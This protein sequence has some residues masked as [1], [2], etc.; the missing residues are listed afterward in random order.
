M[1]V[2]LDVGARPD[3]RSFRS[4]ADKAERYFGD[5]SERIGKRFSDNMSKG[6]KSSDDVVRKSADT[7]V[8]AYERAADAAGRV[9]AEEAKL[10]DLREKGAGR[11]AL[12]AQSERLEKARRSEVSSTR[13]AVGALGEL[14]NAQRRA[15]SSGSALSNLLGGI[16]QGAAGTRLGDLAGQAENLSTRLG[17]ISPMAAGATAGVAALVIGVGAASKALYDLGA[18]WDDIGDGIA[19]RTGKMGSDLKSVTDVVRSVGS[20]VAAP[21][22]QIGDVAGRVSQS[23]RLSGQPLEDMVRTVSQLNEL[24]GEQT[25]VRGLGKAFRQFGVDSTADQMDALEGLASASRATGVSVNDLIGVMNS[26]GKPAKELGLDFGQTAGLVTTLEEAGLDFTKAAPSLSIALKNF[27][28]DGREPQQA[29]RDTVA[30][31]KNLIDAGKDAQAADLAAKTFGKGYIDFLAAIKSGKLDVDSFN[32]ALKKAGPTIDE[33][34][35]STEDWHEE[36]QKLKNT[37]S[38]DLAPAAGVFFGAVNDWLKRTT[39]PLSDLAN[40]LGRINDEMTS[41]AHNAAYGNSRPIFPGV[42]GAQPGTPVTDNLPGLFTPGAGSGT[43]S[44]GDLLTGAQGVPVAGAPGAAPTMALP[45]GL[46]WHPDGGFQARSSSSSGG[47][48]PTFPEDQWKVP[49]PQ[50][51]APVTSSKAG[52]GP[53]GEPGVWQADANTIAD[54]QQSVISTAQSLSEANLHL[55]ELKSQENVAQSA[56]VSAQNNVQQAAAAAD[57]AQRELLESQQGTWKK[58]E[59][60]ADSMSKGMDSIGSALDND[61]GIS[62]GLPGL[63]ENLVKFL[64]NLAFAPALGALSAVSAASPNQGSGLVGVMAANGAFGQQYTPSGVVPVTVTNLPGGGSGSLSAL[65]PGASIPGTYGLP[66]GTDTGGY[67]SSGKAFPAWV[68]AL[69]DRFGVKASTYSGHQ[70]GDR[71]E[72]G[73][74][75]NPG[76]QNRGIDWSG[77]VG[78]MQQFADYLSQI[79]GSLEQAIWQNPSTGRSTEIAGGRSQPGYFAGDLGGHQNHVHTRQSA[80]IPAPGGFS[81]IA[82]GLGITPTPL[83]VSA[84]GGGTGTGA[85]FPGIGGPPQAFGANSPLGLPMTGTA[86]AAAP[87]AGAVSG[88][89]AYPAQGGGGFSGLGGMPMD[90]MMMATSGLDAMAPGAGV[91]AKIGIQLANRT[92]GYMGQVAGIGAS[93]LLETLSVGDNPMGS[94]GKSWIGKLAGGFAGARP[95]LPNMAGQKP[96]PAPGGQQGQPGQQGGTT[97]QNVTINNQAAT[98]DQNG[99]D[100]T[101]HLGAMAAPAGRQ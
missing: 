101:A 47:A 54:R 92:I 6:I 59:G 77:P 34:N 89:Q 78:A 3:E 45:P 7:A 79:P 64:A 14:D 90:A 8:K 67:G 32:D 69:E 2:Y 10:E 11:T 31:I 60:V 62:K 71:H 55:L 16:S 33:L 91:A 30:E 74:A 46:Q 73:Y 49:I 99:K 83:G 35:K 23:L 13:A 56:L 36:W 61:L 20:D 52:I 40:E 68:H 17:G 42:P 48:K 87:N 81:A 66:T 72:A 65:Q 75:P 27:A 86:G 15:A 24:T 94:F 43:P 82:P 44:L 98:P 53:N 84:V 93:G 97:N 100:I 88:G 29:L 4:A 80:P 12:I 76:H 95:A 51:A 26:A 70:E 57:K 39:Q 5:A 96:P 1:P 38:S 50:F 19:A 37:F 25:D 21:L 18:Q 85:G 9:R 22:S 28:R 41:A 58:A 63:A